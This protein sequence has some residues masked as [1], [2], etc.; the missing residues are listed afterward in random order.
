[1]QNDL[2]KSFDFQHAIKSKNHWLLAVCRAGQ[3]G[4]LLIKEAVFLEILERVFKG[5]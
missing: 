5:M 1:M 2:W 3:A 4:R